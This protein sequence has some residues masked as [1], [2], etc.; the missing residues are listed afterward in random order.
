[1]SKGMYSS[2]IVT[3]A[4]IIRQRLEGLRCMREG[5]GELKERSLTPESVSSQT[6]LFLVIHDHDF[7]NFAVLRKEVAKQSFVDVR[8]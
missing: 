4:C 6:L 7:D 8:R 2:C 3:K 1:M 5:G